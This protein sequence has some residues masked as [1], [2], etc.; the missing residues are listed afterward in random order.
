MSD[1]GLLW[2]YVYG[3]F[4]LDT[5]HVSQ[6]WVFQMLSLQ[7]NYTIKNKRSVLRWSQPQERNPW[8]GKQIWEEELIQ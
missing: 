4:D 5:S 8:E 2:V 1:T 7:N 3:V 6:D